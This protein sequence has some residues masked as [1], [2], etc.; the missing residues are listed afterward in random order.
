MSLLMKAPPAEF[1]PL[2][3]VRAAT[4][5]CEDIPMLLL[6]AAAWVDQHTSVSYAHN[7]DAN[8][9]QDVAGTDSTPQQRG[10]PPKAAPPKKVTPVEG[11]NAEMDTLTSGCQR[12]HKHSSRC[13]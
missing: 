11:T 1:L 8:F 7:T 10:P 12:H 3:R 5:G 13:W 2:P 9:E 6:D 4:A